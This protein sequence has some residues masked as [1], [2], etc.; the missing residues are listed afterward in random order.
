L[1]ADATAAEAPA[2]SSISARVAGWCRA[3]GGVVRGVVALALFTGLSILVFALP[4]MGALTTRCVG[5][6]LADTNLYTWSFG[7][8][9]QALTNHLDPLFTTSVWA[10]FGVHLAWVTTL[11]GPAIVMQPI[12]QA[13][14]GLTSVNILMIAAPAT[15][16]WAMYLVCVRVTQRFWPSIVGGAVFGFSTY[17]NQHMRAQLNLVLVLF[18]PLAVYLV[19]RRLD[20]SLHPVAFVPALALVL[21]GEF[22]TATEIFATM[23]LFGGLAYVGALVLGPWELKKRLLMTAVYIAVAYAL[24]LAAVFPIISRLQHNAPPDKAVRPPDLNAIDLLSFVTPSGY[25]RFGGGTF[26]S[27]TSR[28]PSLPQ[29]DTG[30]VG[31]LFVVIAVWFLVQFRRYWWAWFVAG[32]AFLVA[33]LSLGPVLHVNGHVITD[34][35]QKALWSLPLIQHATPDRY[36][37]YLFAALGVMTAAWLAFSAKRFL[38]ARYVVA[39]VAIAAMSIDLA[40]EPHYHGTPDIPAFFTDGTYAEYLDADDVVLGIPS[41]LGGDMMWQERTRFGFRLGRAYIGPIHPLG[42]TNASLGVITTEPWHTLPRENGIR[43]FIRERGVSAVV[44]ADPVPERVLELMDDVI[45]TRPIEVDGVH[46]WLVPPKGPTPKEP[47]TP[48]FDPTPNGVGEDPPNWPPGTSAESE[49][50]GG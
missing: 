47:A 36:P 22:T 43:H 35:P 40:I 27:V 31:V 9:D 11:P 34:V 4:V 20:R 5:S 45:G 48:L 44:A 32:F 33:N 26:A 10:P 14:G 1:P 16:A 19:L 8:M 25:A 18:V 21:A 49:L 39:I 6:C 29:N 41:G 28:F 3:R 15:A 23:T 13:F 46:L 7:W 50:E 30:Y 2:T 17:I 38:W 37:M 12:T 24:A 42:Y